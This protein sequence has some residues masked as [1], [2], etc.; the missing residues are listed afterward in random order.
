MSLL[1]KYLKGW[2][3]RTT[4]PELTPGE[5]VNV[6]VNHYDETEGV[7]IANIGDTK[8]Y[9]EGV[10]PAHLGRKVRVD[11]TEFANGTG[12]GTFQEVVGESSYTG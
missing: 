10:D 6:F 3:F 5:D 8:L 2:T 1:K 7:G 9:I 11:V 4:T 12:R